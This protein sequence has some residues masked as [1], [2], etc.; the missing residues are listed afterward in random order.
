M[1]R[2]SRHPKQLVFVSLKKTKTNN[3]YLVDNRVYRSTQEG[4]K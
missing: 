1:F 3:S 2:M 4:G